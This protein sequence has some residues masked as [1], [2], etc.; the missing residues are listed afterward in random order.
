MLWGRI[1]SKLLSDVL[2]PGLRPNSFLISSR[3]LVC[4]ANEGWTVDPH[5]TEKID[6]AT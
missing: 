2:I 6:D 1:R 4:G 3:G 5:A